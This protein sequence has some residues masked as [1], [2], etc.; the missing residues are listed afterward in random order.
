[1]V[2]GQGIATH[3]RERHQ[4]HG[5]RANQQSIISRQQ[6]LQLAAAGNRPIQNGFDPLQPKLA[7]AQP[8]LEDF[9]WPGALEARFSAMAAAPTGLHVGQARLERFRQRLGLGQ[10][11]E[12]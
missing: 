5:A 7:Q 3:G 4:V 9:G 10:Q 8:K 6:R 2:G 11:Q 1:M 12:R